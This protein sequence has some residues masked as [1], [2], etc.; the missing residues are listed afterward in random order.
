VT[1]AYDQTCF[2]LGICDDADPNDVL[3]PDA[4]RPCSPQRECRHG[5]AVAA[6]AARHTAPQGVAPDA[7]VYAIRVFNPTGT[8]ADLVDLLLALDHARR[9]YD[10]GVDV[11][12]VNLSVA[13]SITFA[14][15]CDSDPLLDA[16]SFRQLF[17]QLKAR[18]IATVVASG[19]DGKVGSIAF[20]AC[21]STSVAVGATDLDDDLA[22]F[23][24]RAS[25]LDLVAPG[26]DE[27]NGSVDPMEIP[28]GANLWAG[29]SFSAPHVAGAF[30]LLTSQ[31]PKASVDQLVGLLRDTGAPVSDPFTGTPYRRLDLANIDAGLAVGQL[32]RGSAGVTG[33]TRSALGDLDGDGRADVVAHGPGPGGGAISYGRPTWGF[34]R[35]SA[36]VSGD[37]LPVVGQLRGAASGP[38]DI[39]WYGPG[40]AADVL[41]VGQPTRTPQAAA[42]AVSGVYTPV[43]GDFDGDGWD[44]ILWYAPG[45]TA[46]PIWFGGA[47]QF[48]KGVTDIRGTYSVHVGD[49]DG[50]ARDDV[51]L[52]SSGSSHSVWFGTAARSFAKTT[53]AAVGGRRVAVGRLDADARDDVVLHGPGASTDRLLLGTASRT[54]TTVAMTI[55]GSYT[56]VTADIDRDGRD[57]VLWYAPG[58][59]PDPVWF[60]LGDGTPAQAATASVSGTYAPL[61]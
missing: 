49:F 21:V 4:G 59:S 33:T 56:P 13:T 16:P 6:V 54:F 9:L 45:G 5:T 29:T 53:L 11:A 61:V 18:G 48:T 52:Y 44:D 32:F 39:L 12:A 7:G 2:D 22:D 19:N 57:E 47:S 1:A 8:Q 36:T 51:L 27:G 17:D 34:E 20:P 37:P 14:G 23:G 28:D 42:V 30:A 41:W 15:A 58:A 25:T 40:G 26:A 46:D 50:D 10:A 60:G 43:V 24:N 35:R 55:S 38:D 3:D 31:L